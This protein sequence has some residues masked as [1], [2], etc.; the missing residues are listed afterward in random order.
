MSLLRFYGSPTDPPDRCSWALVN[1]G[2]EVVVGEGSLASLPRRAARVQ[3]VI[4]AAQVLLARARIPHA[5]RRHAGSVLAFALEEQTAGEPDANQVSWLGA[6]GE[7]DILAVVDKAGLARW[8]EALAAVGIQGHE[9][10]SETLLL[11]LAMD[12]WS[13][14]WNGS[15]G[16]VRTGEFEGA[17]TDCGDCD[18]PP[19]SLRLMLDDAQLEGV[20]PASIALYTI[21]S[22][23]LPDIAAWTRELGVAV[24]P[25]GSWDW[26]TASAAA[27]V[28][29][30]QERQRWQAFTGVVARLRPAA[31]ITGAALAILAIALVIDWVSLAND[32]VALRQQMTARFR[33]VFPDAI[34]VVDPMLQMRRKLAEA[35][36]AA[37]QSD[38]SDFLP[39]IEQVA[40]A[41]SALP[42]GTVHAVSYESGRMTLELSALDPAGVRAVVARLQQSGL[43]VDPLPVSMRAAGAAVV[44]TVRPS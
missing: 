18:T 39:M 6:A 24:C 7:S 28:S 8:R 33:G 19:L 43:S 21:G 23:A 20:R 38:S 41:T 4:P 37:G 15:E 42:T 11:P 31:W 36:H 34:A 2:R 29:L 44:L 14:A 5:A 3:W 30:A 35:R 12:T 22:D 16:F 25:T 10:H 17:A 27:G 26:R 9:V 1:D 40:T 13:L 32:Q